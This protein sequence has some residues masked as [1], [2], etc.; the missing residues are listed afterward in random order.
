MHDPY[1]WI[2]IIG[3]IWGT[4][5]FAAGAIILFLYFRRRKKIPEDDPHAD[6]HRFVN[7]LYLVFA[8]LFFTM[9][10]WVVIRY[11]ITPLFRQ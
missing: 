11:V 7:I 1:A 10:I 6:L 2:L 8:V 9:G 3:V 4:I 5:S